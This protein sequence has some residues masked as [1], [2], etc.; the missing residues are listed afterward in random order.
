[1]HT[2]WGLIAF[3]MRCVSHVSHHIVNF[4][5]I[6]YREADIQTMN[7]LTCRLWALARNDEGVGFDIRE[8]GFNV[9]Q[10]IFPF[11]A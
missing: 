10:A 4:E 3:G 7:R 5:L 11:K 1:M 6:V 2:R 9:P 8:S